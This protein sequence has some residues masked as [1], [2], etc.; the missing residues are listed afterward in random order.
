VAVRLVGLGL[1]TLLPLLAVAGGL[2]AWLLPD[3]T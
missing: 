2:A 1:L 3:T